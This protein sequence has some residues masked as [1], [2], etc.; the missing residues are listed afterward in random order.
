[1][2]VQC[3]RG[4]YTKS[5]NEITCTA[6]GSWKANGVQCDPVFCNALTAPNH[7]NVV[8]E[9]EDIEFRDRVPWK[10]QAR[11][12]CK[13]G[14]QLF[15]ASHASCRDNGTWSTISPQC[16]STPDKTEFHMKF[17]INFRNL[18]PGN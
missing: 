7:G 15:G 14:F 3:D 17:H 8:H 2:E 5:G 18:V 13:E 9:F 16:Q 6:N 4:F 10:G 12:T 1:M 11:F